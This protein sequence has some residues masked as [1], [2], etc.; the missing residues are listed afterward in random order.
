VNPA[1]IVSLEGAVQRVDMELGER[2][3]SFTLTKADGTR[4]T[5]MAGPYRLLL[6]KDFEINV[7]D[8][9]SVRAFP[10][11]RFEGVYVAIELKNLTTGETITLRDDDGAPRWG[12][13]RGREPGL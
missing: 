3:P 13:G 7:G 8:R 10:S 12:P 6:E 11:L 2:F 5:I 9:M 1:T 4:V